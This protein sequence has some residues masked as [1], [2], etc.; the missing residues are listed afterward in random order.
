VSFG[1]DQGFNGKISRCI[2]RALDALGEGVKQSLYFQ[3]QQKYHLDK[4]EIPFK[5]EEVIERLR[6]ILGPTG[7]S[8][9]ERILAREIRNE[10]QLDF[11]EGRPLSA[12]IKEAKEKFLDVSD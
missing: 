7:S 9:V 2:G 4:E 10:F 6:E 11:K 8:F 1:D 12:V 5:P 3:I